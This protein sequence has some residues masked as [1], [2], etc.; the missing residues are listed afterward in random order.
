MFD[1]F[2]TAYGMTVVTMLHAKVWLCCCTSLGLNEQ[3]LHKAFIVTAAASQ[4]ACDSLCKGM[5]VTWS[6]QLLQA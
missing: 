2:L 6:N 3:I 4:Y 1:H 5:M